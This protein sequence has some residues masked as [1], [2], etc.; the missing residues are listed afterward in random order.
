[1]S[2]HTEVH[3]TKNGP[4]TIKGPVRLVGADGSEWT[5]LPDGKPVALCRCGQSGHKP[6]CDGTHN[7]RDFDSN[8]TPDVQPY[9]WGGPDR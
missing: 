8:P 5:D 1:M 2:E 4:Y 6:F 7:K 3:V 9:P